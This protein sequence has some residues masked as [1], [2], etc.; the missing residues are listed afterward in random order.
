MGL[1]TP[2]VAGM[3]WAQAVDRNALLRAER[4]LAEI[5]V[6][7]KFATDEELAAHSRE[8]VRRLSGAVDGVIA[9]HARASDGTC[10][11]CSDGRLPRLLHPLRPG[12]RWPCLTLR[13]I[14]RA[15]EVAP[16]LSG[17]EAA[18]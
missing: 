18:R 9:L 10:R 1:S 13:V 17:V 12:R 4:T 8:D 7:L 15:I 5:R 6:R 3:T 16:F 14:T 2:L 11:S